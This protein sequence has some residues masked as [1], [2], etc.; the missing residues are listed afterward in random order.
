MI[1]NLNDIEPRQDIRPNVN[2]LTED[3][4]ILIRLTSERYANY[5]CGEVLDRFH[6]VIGEAFT[7]ERLAELVTAA[8]RQLAAVTR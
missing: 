7:P 8:K 3:G 1:I 6:N 4:K 5:P 2:H